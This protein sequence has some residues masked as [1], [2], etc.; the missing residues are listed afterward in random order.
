M[1][2]SNTSKPL[3]PPIRTVMQAGAARFASTCRLSPDLSWLLSFAALFILPYL[4]KAYW[5]GRDIQ[6]YLGSANELYFCITQVLA[7]DALL[8]S[9]TMLA[10]ALSLALRTGVAAGLLIAASLA[11]CTV[12]VVDTI[13]ILN[14]STRLNVFDIVSYLK[15]TPTY[16]GNVLDFWRTTMG[17]ALFILFCITLKAFFRNRVH[18]NAKRTSISVCAIALVV[19]SLSGLRDNKPYI[20]SHLFKNIIEYT[21][22]TSGFYAGY[23]PSFVQHMAETVPDA[24]Q[25]H[26]SGD[27]AQPNIILLVVESLSSYHSAHFSGI[28]NLTPQLDAIAKANLSFTNFHANGYCTVDGMISLLTGRLPL[29]AMDLSPGSMRP[30]TGFEGHMDLADALPRQLAKRGYSTEYLTSGDVT[31]SDLDVWAKSI[32]FDVVEGNEHPV[33]ADKPRFT[34]G[35]VQDEHLFARVLEKAHSAPYFA[36]VMTTGTHQPYLCPEQGLY[37]E[38]CTFRAFDDQVGRFYAELTRRGFFKNGLLLIVGDH[39]AMTAI[40]NAEAQRF[41]LERT[42]SRIPLIVCN[43]GRNS[44]SVDT[45]FQ[46]VDIHRTLLNLVSPMKTADHWQGDF[47]GAPPRPARYIVHV[48]PDARDRLTVFKGEETLA[49]KLNGDATDL[50][51]A[52]GRPLAHP[53]RAQILDMVNRT[54]ISRGRQN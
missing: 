37:S 3:Q 38:Q 1:H 49:V 30:L 13:I 18:S 7:N 16:I 21:H 27:T 28:S 8:V 42:T 43:G 20:N 25:V 22:I 33:Y 15:H 26:W 5:I 34:L 51:A 14:F 17:L 19:A 11:M 54:R 23:S 36:L 12:Y 48:N 39:R 35:A 50:V 10:V 2:T 46:Q 52:S 40:S 9:A 31:F 24:H 4:L 45:P 53:D 6:W 47:L 44:G 29:P 41:G 32:G